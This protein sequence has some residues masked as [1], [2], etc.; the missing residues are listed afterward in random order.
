MSARLPV[1]LVV[2]T[3]FSNGPIS[4]EEASVH[5]HA[6]IFTHTHIM[7][8][9][10]FVQACFISGSTRSLTVYVVILCGQLLL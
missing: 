4:E 5:G 2:L 9:F 1:W 10:L 8:H 6:C 3:H 7:F